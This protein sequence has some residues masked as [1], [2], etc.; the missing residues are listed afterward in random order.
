MDQYLE[1]SSGAYEGNG[2]LRKRKMPV[3]KEHEVLKSYMPHI[4]VAPVLPPPTANINFKY[5]FMLSYVH[6]GA[7][8]RTCAARECE[9]PSRSPAAGQFC[10][11]WFALAT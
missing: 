2:K 1:A 9:R 5:Y 7:P 10:P 6:R 4:S 11:N 3:A 8:E